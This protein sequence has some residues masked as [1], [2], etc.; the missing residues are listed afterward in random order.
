[1]FV[2]DRIE[3]STAVLE[4]NGTLQNI[5]LQELPDG[6]KE[7]DMLE[8]TPDGWVLCPEQAAERRTLLAKRRKQLLGGTP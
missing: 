8:Q 1:M 7:G 3:G 6:A 4:Q 2:I 5:P